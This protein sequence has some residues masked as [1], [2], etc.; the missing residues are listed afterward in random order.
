MNWQ[1]PGTGTDYKQARLSTDLKHRFLF[2]QPPK[3]SEGQGR[4]LPG[5][6]LSPA[7][8]PSYLLYRQWLLTGKAARA[9]LGFR[10]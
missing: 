7:Q 4:L 2:S 10:G 6:T 5:H 3:V 9:C 1:S 8:P